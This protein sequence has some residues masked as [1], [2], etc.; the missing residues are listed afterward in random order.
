MTKKIYLGSVEIYAPR[1]IVMEALKYISGGTALDLGAGFGRHSLFLASKGFVVTAVETGAEQIEN[2]KEKASKLN[3][4]IRTENTDIRHFD[5]HGQQYDLILS[6]MVLHFLSNQKEVITTIQ[7]M[8]E[9]T[10]QGGINV[11]SIYTDK[12]QAGL[13]PCL[14]NVEELRKLYSEWEIIRLDELKGD[15]IVDGP[16]KGKLIWRVEMIAKKRLSR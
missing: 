16:E 5:P 12:S 4:L 7:K 13:R 10:R 9:A 2:L 3:V 6:T 15:D 14:L 1:E 11:I 8:K